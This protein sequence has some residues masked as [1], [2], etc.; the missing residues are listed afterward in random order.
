MWINVF[1]VVV[2]VA[3]LQ[4]QQ[5]PIYSGPQV[6]EEIRSFVMSGVFGDQA[7]E[8][9]DLVKQAGGGPLLLMFV[10]ERSRP[11]FG[12]S[13][14]LARF[15]ASLDDGQLTC[16]IC[17]LTA[18]Q[19]EA[20][21]WMNRIQQ[22]FNESVTVGISVDGAEGPGDYGL[23][24]NVVLTVIAAD[25]NKVAANFALIQ[26]AL[27]A[28]GQKVVDAVS[29]MLGQETPPKITQFLPRRNRD[30]QTRNQMSP[31][32]GTLLRKV[33]NKQATVEQVDETAK[34][35]EKYLQEHP[36]QKSGLGAACRR[37]VNSDRLETYGIER[38][39]QYI[40]DWSEKY[41]LLAD[42]PTEEMKK[43]DDKSGKDQKDKK[44]DR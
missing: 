44:P 1:A 2:V 30:A 41:M 42:R 19:S 36:E 8:E 26:P 35:I 9:I 20:R 7:Y 34:E 33:I 25:N 43:S 27:E 38:A 12:L 6:G 14:A 10:H 11:A 40:S 39:Q 31:E 32:L 29:K 17:Y 22:Y 3:P 28:D 37:I 16:G 18:D 13:N 15:A 23:N 5:E 24:R 4:E 21:N